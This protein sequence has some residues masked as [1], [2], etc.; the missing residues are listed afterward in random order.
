[1][2]KKK[3]MQLFLLLLVLSSLTLSAQRNGWGRG[4]NGS[5]GCGMN[6]DYIMLLPSEEISVAERT[7]LIKMRE[8]EKL[9][10]DVYRQLHDRWGMNVF[11]NIAN[12]EQRHMDALAVLLKK[13]EIPDPV[14]D[15][16]QGVFKDPALSKLYK[17]LMEKGN[18]SLKDALIVGASIEDLDIFDLHEA[19][20]KVDNMDILFVFGNLKKG[21]E[22]HMRAFSR[23]LNRLNYQYKAQYISQEDLD[24]ILAF[25][26]GNGGWHGGNGGRRGGR[27]RGHR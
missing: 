20:L 21:S 14:G 17:T 6:A 19:L 11:G 18:L 24:A 22:N 23:Q 26:S 13:Y 16:L 1:M 12:S 15:D 2:E 9:A 25:A 10:R 5:G 4:G 7:A 3:L 8:E 27:G